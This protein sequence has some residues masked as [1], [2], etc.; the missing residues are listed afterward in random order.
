M[1]KPISTKNNTPLPQALPVI[2]T[3]TT[4]TAVTTSEPISA[5]ST[6]LPNDSTVHSKKV[7]SNSPSFIFNQQSRKRNRRHIGEIV[8]PLSPA[9]LRSAS[10]KTKHYSVLERLSTNVASNTE[11]NSS[12]PESSAFKVYQPTSFQR[13]MIQLKN[14]CL[15]QYDNINHSKPIAFIGIGGVGK[16]VLFRSWVKS[17]QQDS[18]EASVN[19]VTIGETVEARDYLSI[20]NALGKSLVR[21]VKKAADTITD[22]LVKDGLAPVGGGDDGPTQRATV[23]CE[24]LQ[25]YLN[26]TLTINTMQTPSEYLNGW[27]KRVRQKINAMKIWI[28]L[29]GIDSILDKDLDGNNAAEARELVSAIPSCVGLI[30]GCRDGYHM[31]D[32]WKLENWTLCKVNPWTEEERNSFLKFQ[33]STAG[34]HVEEKIRRNAALVLQTPE[35]LQIAVQEACRLGSKCIDSLIEHTENSITLFDY[36]LEQW[37]QDERFEPGLLPCVLTAILLSP[38]GASPNQIALTHGWSVNNILALEK[39]AGNFVVFVDD[40]TIPTIPRKQKMNNKGKTNTLVLHFPNVDFSKAVALRYLGTDVVAPHVQMI[41]IDTR[42]NGL[43][44]KQLMGVMNISETASRKDKRGNSMLIASAAIINASA[45]QFNELHT[46]IGRKLARVALSQIAKASSL[47]SSKSA[48][49]IVASMMM[50]NA[51]ALTNTKTLTET[52]ISDG[53]N[54]GKK[55]EGE[56]KQNNTT[57]AKDTE[58]NSIEVTSLS[59]SAEEDKKKRKARPSLQEISSLLHKVLT[60][61]SMDLLLEEFTKGGKRHKAEET[62]AEK[63]QA[64][65]TQAEKTQAEKT[66]AEKTQ[67]EKTQAEKKKAEKNERN[68]DV[69]ILTPTSEGN[70]GIGGNYREFGHLKANKANAEFLTK[71]QGGKI[72]D[73]NAAMFILRR[74]PFVKSCQKVLPCG[75]IPDEDLYTLFDALDWTADS[76][77]DGFVSWEDFV[78]LILISARGKSLETSPEDNNSKNIN[79]INNSDGINENT[80]QDSLVWQLRKPDPTLSYANIS[81]LPKEQRDLIS[82]ILPVYNDFVTVTH[83]GT[84]TL[85]TDKMSNHQEI[86]AKKSLKGQRNE[87]RLKMLESDL[88]AVTVCWCPKSR[89]ICC[90]LMRRTAPSFVGLQFLEP[91]HNWELSPHSVQFDVHATPITAMSCYY[92]ALPSDLASAITTEKFEVIFVGCEDGSIRFAEL[93]DMIHSVEDSV[94]FHPRDSTSLIT[95]IKYVPEIHQ[96][97]TCSMDGNI[98]LINFAMAG[99]I[100]S[101]LTLECRG[102]AGVFNWHSRPV[103]SI[104]YCKESQCFL[105]AGLDTTIYLWQPT[106]FKILKAINTGHPSKGAHLLEGTSQVVTIDAEILYRNEKLHQCARVFNL[107]S[108]LEQQSIELIG[109]RPQAKPVQGSPIVVGSVPGACSGFTFDLRRGILLIGSHKMRILEREKIWQPSAVA[110]HEHPIVAVLFSSHHTQLTTVDTRGIARV[111]NVRE[112]TLLFDFKVVPEPNLLSAKKMPTVSAGCLGFAQERLFTGLN[113]GDISAWR[114]YNGEKLQE[115]TAHDPEPIISI[116]HLND[117]GCIVALSMRGTISFW[118]DIVQLKPIQCIRYIEGTSA[119]T[120]NFMSIHGNKTFAEALIGD[121]HGRIVLWNALSSY[122]KADRFNWNSD[123]GPAAKNKKISVSVSC[124]HLFQGASKSF[125]VTGSDDGYIRMYYLSIHRSLSFLRSVFSGGFSPPRDGSI[126]LGP[127]TMDV[128][129]DG[130]EIIVGDGSG[131]V[132]I[133]SI[134]K[135]K[136]AKMELDVYPVNFQLRK[137]WTTYR[138]LHKNSVP[139]ELE[140]LSVSTLVSVKG[141]QQL[142]VGNT[143]SVKLYTRD[144]ILIGAFGQKRKWC[145]ENLVPTNNLSLRKDWDLFCADPRAMPIDWKKA[146]SKQ[147]AVSLHLQK[148]KARREQEEQQKQERLHNERVQ[149]SIHIFN[150]L[151]LGEVKAK[152]LDGRNNANLEETQG[153]AVFTHLAMRSG[154]VNEKRF[155]ERMEKRRPLPP[156]T[157]AAI[158]EDHYGGKATF[159]PATPFSTF[160]RLKNGLHL[161]DPVENNGNY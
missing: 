135:F 30:V 139:P 82:T 14:A 101:G 145:Y 51:E 40:Q 9:A 21:S 153:Q 46:K 60:S 152:T 13:T 102:I 5:P 103:L 128:S 3:A 45:K 110:T 25:Q 12:T 28:A 154:T 95:V 6:L 114:I 7:T 141:R 130:T 86:T 43:F 96:I 61:E 77:R 88:K 8:H 121:T 149:N 144:G 150:A 15:E 73:Y 23:L 68:M 37:E 72:K 147:I 136:Q 11:N 127:T 104:Q 116:R 75:L 64:E 134:S 129:E 118:R 22:R 142:I 55:V 161:K 2:A 92:G 31:L 29:D 65:K 67:A 84:L 159:L 113:C 66:Q 20:V 90:S 117:I 87:V 41:Y 148:L 53:G 115:Y 155:Q 97:L 106:N 156:G 123:G 80:L 157:P 131:G 47:L 107:F 133:W 143:Y 78:D 38:R 76:D 74:E 70:L 99:N 98:R 137:Y 109:V 122:A 1:S 140:D 57:A 63:T 120:L 146:K 54:N 138:P 18:K 27:I 94:L 26:G 24:E 91:L 69:K 16:T 132:R 111:W 158:F 44:S 89:V 100:V 32:F 4:A 105:S 36:V 151:S 125:L 17:F 126:V 93:S 71:A 19:L 83:N 33:W 58:D 59:T 56:T 34:C 10:S 48:S 124:G 62:Q 119:G 35:G 52:I 108:G 39:L 112:S 50:E 42:D 160:K 79:E 81:S 49:K 85:I